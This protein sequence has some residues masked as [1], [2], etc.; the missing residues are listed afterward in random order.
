MLEIGPVCHSRW[1]TTEL[2][3]CRIWVS[4]HGLSAINLQNLT[5]IAEFIVGVYFPN[6]FNI[7]VKSCWV[8]GSRHTLYQLELLRSRRKSVLDIVIPSIKRSAWYAHSEATSQAMICSESKEEFKLMLVI[9]AIGIKEHLIQTLMLKIFL[10]SL[11][12]AI[13]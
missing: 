6:W 2:R 3:F 5:W 7:K 12:G 1:L 10:A 11:T 4:L 9:I 8:E 13:M